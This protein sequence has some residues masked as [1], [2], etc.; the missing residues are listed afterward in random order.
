MPR[1]RFRPGDLAWLAITAY[2]VSCPRGEMLSEAMDRYLTR[3]PRLR[4]LPLMEAAAFYV[5][6]HCINR[7]PPKYDALFWAA[8]LLGR[9]T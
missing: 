3:H 5:Y 1:I 6:L 7:L 2:E 8:R 9:A 4:H